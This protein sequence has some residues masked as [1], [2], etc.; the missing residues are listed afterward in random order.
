LLRNHTK[1]F[2]SLALTVMAASHAV[3]DQRMGRIAIS[4]NDPISIAAKAAA[5]LR[6]T[7]GGNRP[8]IANPDTYWLESITPLN[9]TN[10]TWLRYILRPQDNDFDL[11]GDGFSIIGVS[12]PNFGTAE[13]VSNLV[14]YLPN[15]GYVGPDSM[16]Y[17][18]VDT[19]ANVST[20]T[21]NLTLLPS[22]DN[23]AQVQRGYVT[24]AQAPH[25]FTDV[26]VDSDGS[27]YVAGYTVERGDLG[28]QTGLTLK[29]RPDGTQAYGYIWYKYNHDGL[30]FDRIVLGKSRVFTW[31]RRIPVRK[32]VGTSRPP[33]F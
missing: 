2:C 10:P 13:F 17:N 8:P 15:I 33:W 20:S 25:V 29:F 30:M 14:R 24:R 18:I 32:T 19:S 22:Q 21:M 9:Y 16:S 31:A 1:L 5:G 3:A 7:P 28:W 23:A 12:S 11:D 26:K 6:L 4:A 27:T